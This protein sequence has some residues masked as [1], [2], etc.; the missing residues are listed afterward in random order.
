MKGNDTAQSREWRDGKLHRALAQKAAREAKRVLGFFEREMPG[1]KR[2]RAAIDAL[3]AW[4]AGERTLGM[5]AVRKLALGSHAAARSAR[6]S[7][8]IAAARAAG[9]AIAT[10]HAPTHALATFSY[11]QKAIFASKQEKGSAQRRKYSTEELHD[12]S[13]AITSLVSK[14]EKVQMKLRKGT[15]QQTLVVNRLKALRISAALLGHETRKK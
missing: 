10:W 6:S 5:A 1:D 7:A 15:A 9:Q 4:V 3:L 13:R 11:A 12:A 8:A 14:L 2:P